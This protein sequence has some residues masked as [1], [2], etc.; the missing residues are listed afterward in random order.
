[1]GSRIDWDDMVSDLEGQKT[2]LETELADV[3]AVLD[4]VRKRAAPKVRVADVATRPK[5]G[6]GK[7]PAAAKPVKTRASGDDAEKAKAT[8]KKMYERGDVVNEIAKAVGRSV[9]TVY[10]WASAEKWDR[11]NPGA[12]SPAAAAP[13]KPAAGT[14]L[15]GNVRC[16]N[17]ECGA[18]TD[19]DPCRTC[20]KML[21]RKGW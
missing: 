9:Q 13:V 7:K 18:W 3:E 10:T 6:N 8:A 1:M 5:A 11:P 19:H 16:T 4:V 14:P 15:S 21:R 20:G 17:P 12:A 2:A